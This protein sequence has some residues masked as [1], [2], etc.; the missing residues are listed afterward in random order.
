MSHFLTLFYFVLFI[1][2]LLYA[3]PCLDA[4]MDAVHLVLL[5]VIR[6]KKDL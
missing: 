1:E 2:C 6:W 3:R 5:A 4:F